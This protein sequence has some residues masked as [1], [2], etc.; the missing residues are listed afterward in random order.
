MKVTVVV[1][2]MLLTFVLVVGP[3]AAQLPVGAIYLA[4]GSRGQ[5]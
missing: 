4:R 5:G 3:A 1:L 2:S